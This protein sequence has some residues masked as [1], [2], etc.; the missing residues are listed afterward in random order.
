[1]QLAGPST[2]SL[3][4]FVL[5][6]SA[7]PVSNGYSRNL[8]SGIPNP[9]HYP[10]AVCKPTV[11]HLNSQHKS[12]RSMAPRSRQVML[13]CPS[14]LQGHPDFPTSITHLLPVSPDLRKAYRSWSPAETLGSQVLPPLSF[15]ACHWPYPG[16]PSGALT[17]C[18]PDGVGLLPINRGSACIPAQ[19][20]LSLSRTLPAIFV[21]PSIY[22]AAPFALRCGLRLWPAPLTG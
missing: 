2:H 3:R 20:G 19:Q 15:T 10:Y 8:I 11:P 5:S 14:S 13:S 1:M 7:A 18:F 9:A 12:G 21:Q 17:L 22:E 6:L 16:S 4:R